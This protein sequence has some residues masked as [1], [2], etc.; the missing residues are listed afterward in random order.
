MKEAQLNI[1][2]KQLDNLIKSRYLIWSVYL[3]LLSFFL[4]FA[5]SKL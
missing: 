4:Q 2:N 1:F 3:M 5:S